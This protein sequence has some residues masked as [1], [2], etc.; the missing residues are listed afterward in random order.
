ML[1]ST[2]AFHM[3]QV[4]DQDYESTWIIVILE[5]ATIFKEIKSIIME[6]FQIG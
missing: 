4:V 1:P 5:K 2:I 6:N 3:D